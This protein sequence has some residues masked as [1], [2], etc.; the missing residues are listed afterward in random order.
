MPA[1][2]HA[3]FDPA[4]STFTHV[5]YDEITNHAAIIDPVL[6]YH[7]SSGRIRH[8]NTERVAHFIEKNSLHVDWILETHIHADHLS[9]GAWLKQ[10]LGGRLSIGTG[11]T[12]VTRT[13]NHVYNTPHEIPE[14]GRHFDHLFQDGEVFTIGSLNAT[15]IAVPGHTPADMAYRV[16]DD[17]FV[18]D[19]LFSPA[20]GSARCDFPGGNPSTLY[21]SAKK[22]LSLGDNLRLHLCHDYPPA[23]QEPRPWVSV[24]EQRRD[25][26]HLN[27]AIT[28][29]EFVSLRQERDRQL[30]LPQLIIPAIQVNLRAGNLPP[31][32]DNGI[33]YLKIPLNLL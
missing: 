15:A 31:A 30:E 28:E 8:D 26:I 22:L 23:G 5:V 20:S 9:S 12:E 17:V 24:A 2:T 19:T 4:T 3:F 11:I 14:D 27:D 1:K 10:R 16:G 18:G 7:P 33:S 21:H 32:E 13:F 29:Q 6:D 25:N